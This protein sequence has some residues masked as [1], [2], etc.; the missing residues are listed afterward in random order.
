MKNIMIIRNTMF[1]L[2]PKEKRIVSGSKEK[3]VTISTFIR[4]IYKTFNQIQ[5]L[6][7]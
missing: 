3:N 5:V 2:K 1:E 7:P 4:N 6:E